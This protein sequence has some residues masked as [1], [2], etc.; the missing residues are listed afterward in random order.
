MK[1]SK[2]SKS[3]KPQRKRSA[4][5]DTVEAEA[6]IA[7]TVVAAGDKVVVV[8]EEEVAARHHR[9]ESGARDLLCFSRNDHKHHDTPGFSACDDTWFEALFLFWTERTCFAF[10]GGEFRLARLLCTHSTEPML[11][12]SEP[13][14]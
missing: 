5:A 1:S 11:L 13:R 3:N 10:V 12:W 8:G 2:S 6:E 4:A 14:V 7:A 9:R